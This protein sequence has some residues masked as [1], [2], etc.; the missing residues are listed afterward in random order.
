MD[1]AKRIRFTPQPRVVSR[2]NTVHDPEIT[3]VSDS[4][5]G[6]AASKNAR[7]AASLEK[8]STALLQEQKE[9]REEAVM[10]DRQQTEHEN[11]QEQY[12]KLFNEKAA[13]DRELT[14]LTA[15]RDKLRTQ[16]EV[17]IAEIRG[18][19][20][21]LEALRTLNLRSSDDK[22][23]EITRLRK[24]LEAANLE[25]EKARTSAKTQ[26]QTLDFLKEQY[27]EAQLSAAQAQSEVETLTSTNAKLTQKAS[28][29]AAKLKQMHLDRSAKHLMQ[30]NKALQNENAILK[31]RLKTN[32]EELV[33]AKSNS[34]RY[35]YGTRGQST[36]PQPKNRSR[37][38]SPAGGSRAAR[39][40]GRIS[41]L[42]AEGM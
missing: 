40:G 6:T 8:V 11:R 12:R 24:E 22:N 16:I 38:A 27:R 35:A 31:A 1:P 7:L 17:H 29:E 42:V 3:R 30:Q 36:T 15:I 25:L 2:P 33:R 41:N 23:V 39:G 28:G 26:D 13:V 4:M 34:G 14:N 18:L 5:P 19:R 20:D 37:A 10:W 9:R 32:E 21:E